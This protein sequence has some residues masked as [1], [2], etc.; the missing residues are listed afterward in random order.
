MKRERRTD[1][2]AFVYYFDWAEMLLDMPADMRLKIDDAIKR[3][4]VFGEEPTD[5]AVIYSPFALI[6]MQ[7]D[8]NNT[9]YVT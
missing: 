6:R 8:R 7:I 4:A 3:Y 2:R 9:E 1:Q 5:P